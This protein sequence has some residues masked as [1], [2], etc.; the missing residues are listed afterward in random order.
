MNVKSTIVFLVLMI[1]LGCIEKLDL[2]V[3]TD[4]MLIV[5]AT[6]TDTTEPS[7]RLSRSGS[8]IFLAETGA[9]VVVSDDTGESFVLTESSPGLYILNNVVGEVGKT[10]TLRIETSS[11]RIYE[12]DPE[13][14]VP[15]PAIDCL[16]IQ[17]DSAV[18]ISSFGT[19]T[20]SLRWAI[21]LKTSTLESNTF[22]KWQFDGLYQYIIPGF[23]S[24]IPCWFRDSG[25]V[26]FLNVHG[27]ENLQ[28]GSEVLHKL[29]INGGEAKYENY[30]L[31]LDQ[32]SLNIGAYRYWKNIL[33]QRELEGSLFDPPPTSN[34]GNIYNVS[35]RSERVLGYF[36]VS[37]VHEFTY[38]FNKFRIPY[39]L[40]LPLFEQCAR[41][42]FPPECF[43]CDALGGDT[44]IPPDWIYP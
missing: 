18:N 26:N 15:V 29:I 37:S 5:D 20:T 13:L 33:D 43:D 21:W 40:N 6:L 22:L 35:D 38:P 28:P 36:T 31:F 1:L 30:N 3:E 25:P 10:Y 19:E 42:P 12:S 41:W 34:R 44:A 39:S 11:G 16:W 17:R 2:D 23:P 32:M 27:V 4:S 9:T 24:G 8:D 7:V 14:M